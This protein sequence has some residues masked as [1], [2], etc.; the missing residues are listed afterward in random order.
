M[1]DTSADM[2]LKCEKISDNNNYSNNS[3][4]YYN[5]Q[6]KIVK[7]QISTKHETNEKPLFYESNKLKIT[8]TI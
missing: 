7:D 4:N 5:R 3:H 1:R 6:D 2:P 8:E